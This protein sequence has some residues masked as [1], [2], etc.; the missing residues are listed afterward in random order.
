MRAYIWD[1]MKQ[2]LKQGGAIPGDDEN[3]Y[4]ELIAVETVPTL[5]G[6]IQL[7][8]KKEMKKRDLPSPNRA[9]ALALSFAY[10]VAKK[11]KFSHNNRGKLE[12]E[13][14]PT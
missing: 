5:N 7:E 14:N 8:S 1:E 13:Y 3:L 12:S 10:P 2:W 11:A 9:D 4:N 6:I